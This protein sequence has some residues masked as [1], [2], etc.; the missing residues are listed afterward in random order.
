MALTLTEGKDMKMDLCPS[1]MGQFKAEL[2]ERQENLRLLLEPNYQQLHKAQA[3][4]AEQ[5]EIDKR[6]GQME[7]IAKKA[8]FT[9]R[10][11]KRKCFVATACYGHDLAPEVVTLQAFRDHVLSR[12]RFGRAV[13]EGYYAVAPALADLLERSAIGRTLV[14]RLLLRPIVA[15]CVRRLRSDTLLE[16]NRGKRG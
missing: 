10:S 1:C 16:E 3:D 4:A 2:A 13:V 8:H 14:R 5:R 15:M 7:K 11:G 12:S 9:L 6:I